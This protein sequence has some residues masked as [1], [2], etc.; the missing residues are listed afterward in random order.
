MKRVINIAVI[1]T[2]TLQMTACNTPT[3][4]VVLPNDNHSLTIDM[5][6]TRVSFGEWKDN[7]RVGLVW[8][9]EDCIAAN[10]QTSN[11]AQ[12]DAVEPNIATFW[13]NEKL[14][15]PVNIL[16]P[17][18]FYKSAT[19]ITLPSVQPLSTAGIGTNTLPVAAYIANEGDTPV[20]KHL[21]G[22]IHLR[23]KAASGEK[24]DLHPI[25][26]VEFMGGDSEQVCGDFT[27]DYENATLTPTSTKNM[28]LAVRMDGPLSPTEATNVYIVV[29][30]REYKK[31]YTIRITDKN[32]HYMT[33]KKESAQ[34]VRNG[35]IVSMPEFEFESMGF[36]LDVGV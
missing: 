17:A 19:T 24:Q 35:V 7:G 31:G 12:I 32:G 15:Y 16:Y 5:E 14:S 3:E 9:E 28:K 8:D 6:A 2:A 27:I 29:P 13:F 26:K 18:S 30:A 11:K 33:K 22:I 10:G 20:L 21:T 36:S 34:T 23:I 25:S 1:L 4:E